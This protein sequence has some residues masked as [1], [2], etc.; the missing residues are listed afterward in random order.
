VIVDPWRNRLQRGL[1][2]SQRAP[3]RRTLVERCLRDGPDALSAAE[4]TRLV[5]DAGLLQTLHESVW[6]AGR[7]A[8]WGRRIEKLCRIAN[9]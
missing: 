9:E 7:G 1:A 8:Y 2:S 6:G 4:K 5:R 3:D